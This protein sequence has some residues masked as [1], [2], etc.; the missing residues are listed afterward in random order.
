M[1]SLGEST[2][3]FGFVIVGAISEHPGYYV[4][5]GSH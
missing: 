5:D 2:V 3:G 1:E 4:I